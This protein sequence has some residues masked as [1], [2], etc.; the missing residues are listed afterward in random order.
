MLAMKRRCVSS[1]FSSDFGGT[2]MKTTTLSAALL[3][4]VLLAMASPGTGE[5]A[6]IA[7]IEAVGTMQINSYASGQIVGVESKEAR[8]LSYG[9]NYTELTVPHGDIEGTASVFLDISPTAI[10]AETFMRSE[11]EPDGFEVGFTNSRAYVD[12]S[13]TITGPV[14][15]LFTVT[16][17]SVGPPRLNWV[18][19]QEVGGSILIDTEHDQTPQLLSL[20]PATYRLHWGTDTANGI[21]QADRV[22]ATLQVVPEPSTLVF[23]F[24][25]GI[26]FAGWAWRWLRGNRGFRLTAV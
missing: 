16:Q 10:V 20:E 24:T 18:R 26:V 3:A 6:P 11:V 21:E 12:A 23:F 17:V 15:V 7:V 2:L 8:L 19:L 13:F 4:A 25:G 14:D 5:A 9:S 22:T 1:S